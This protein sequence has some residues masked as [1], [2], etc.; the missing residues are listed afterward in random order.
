MTLTARR[1]MHSAET[2]RLRVQNDILSTMDN[3]RVTSLV[4]LDLRCAFDTVDHAIL[5]AF[6]GQIFSG[7]GPSSPVDHR[8]SVSEM[9]LPK[10]FILN[11]QFSRVLY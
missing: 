3:G 7:L 4:L 5:L 11:S 9:S 2:A 10:Q 8:L 1:E 6:V